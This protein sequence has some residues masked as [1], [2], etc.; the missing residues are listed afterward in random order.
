MSQGTDYGEGVSRTTAATDPAIHV[1]PAGVV[2]LVWSDGRAGNYEIYV[3]VY[4]DVLGWRALGG[5]A[6]GFGISDSA[7]SSRD[8]SL[9]LMPSGDLVVSWTE[10]GLDG[11]TSDILFSIWN[12]ATWSAPAVVPV[13]TGVHQLASHATG[14]VMASVN[15]VGDVTVSHYDGTNFTTV[16]TFLGAG[17]DFDL[18]VSGTDI[19]LATS[20]NDLVTVREYDGVSWSVLASTPGQ[21]PAVAYLGA[22]LYLALA[23]DG[24][25]ILP[26]Q[27]LEWYQVGGSLTPLS[28]SV[29]D[30]NV[31][32]LDLASGGGQ[33]QLVWIEDVTATRQ[34][35]GGV[36]YALN[37]DGTTVTEPLAGSSSDARGVAPATSVPGDLAFAAASDGTMVLALMEWGDGPSVLALRSMP[38]AAANTFVITGSSATPLSVG[39]GDNGKV[40]FF[41]PG[42][43]RDIIDLTGASGV[44]FVHADW[45]GVIETSGVSEFSILGSRVG[46]LT[47]AQTGDEVIVLDSVLDQISLNADGS[48]LIADNRITALVIDNPF[49]G[50]ITRNVIGGG[51]VGVTYHAPAGLT[52]NRISGSQTGLLI[53]VASNSDA[54]GYAAGSGDNL[55]IGNVLGVDLVMGQIADQVI[56]D[57]EIGVSGNLGTILGPNFEK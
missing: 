38:G 7:T 44:S 48:G 18:F 46:D 42:A 51:S 45:I 36:I 50:S 39:S 2:Y 24:G 40:F 37:F 30:G 6:S 15:S 56:A 31:R 4:D 54:P 29:A 49:T 20:V 19:A 5:S 25:D 1:S 17:T 33:L 26:G 28:F 32:D 34:G 22:D 41:T 16:G 23:N 14:V 35:G 55:I 12:G 8:A 57:N 43:T 52:G 47:L 13:S 21:L 27:R 53:S 3:A 10:F 11:T 9:A